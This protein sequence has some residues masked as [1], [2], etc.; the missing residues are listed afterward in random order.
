MEQRASK[1]IV[2]VHQKRTKCVDNTS[3]PTLDKD[4]EQE[5]S[6]TIAGTNRPQ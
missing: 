6:A 4:N 5:D 2:E 3:I 1:V